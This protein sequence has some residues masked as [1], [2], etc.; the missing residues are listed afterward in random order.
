[1]TKSQKA[2]QDEA[3]DLLRAEVLPGDVLHT[4]VRSVARS[5]MSRTID[6]YRLQDGELRCL[7]GLVARALDYRRND[8]GA[9]K[10]SG[11]G[12]NMG[13]AVVYEVSAVLFGAGFACVGEEKRCPSNDHNNGDHSYRPH[14]SPSGRLSRSRDCARCKGT[15]NVERGYLGG[16]GG[17]ARRVPGT[18]RVGPGHWHTSGGY[19]LRQE[20]I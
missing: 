8:A 19:A 11:C 13:F 1:M 12:M 14:L 9:L 6:V 20:W 5:G 15:G 16:P 18:G 7:S 2:E 10:V 4:V 3:R 17:H